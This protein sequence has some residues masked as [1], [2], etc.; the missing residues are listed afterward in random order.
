MVVDRGIFQ[1]PI[2]AQAELSPQV[3]ERLLVLGGHTVAELDEVTAA[4]QSGAL[5]A[6]GSG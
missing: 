3:F 4:D 1:G 2:D 5:L 6:V